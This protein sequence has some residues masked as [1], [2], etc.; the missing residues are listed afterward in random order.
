MN[1]KTAVAVTVAVAAAA[2]VNEM[3][4]EVGRAV[5]HAA[6]VAHVAEIGAVPDGLM[7]GGATCTAGKSMPSRTRAGRHFSFYAID[8]LFNSRC[9]KVALVSSRNIG[10]IQ[11]KNG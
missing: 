4:E 3:R 8:V 7:K 10:H 2:T 9:V 5:G 1:L 11:G 6:A